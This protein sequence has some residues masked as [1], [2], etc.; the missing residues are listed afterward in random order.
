M[1]DQQIQPQNHEPKDVPRAEIPL[2]SQGLIY[3]PEHPLH[4]KDTV[5][6]RMMTVRDEDLLSSEPLIRSRRAID[7]FIKSALGGNVDASS[8]C[9][10]DR[11]AIMF[12]F[13]ATGYGTDY[14]AKVTC[15][16]CSDTFKYTFDLDGMNIKQL[17][18][19]PVVPFTNLFEIP[20]PLPDLGKTVQFS[21][22]TG[23]SEREITDT[24]SA[25]SKKAKHAVTPEVSLR[26]FY[27]IQ[28]IGNE[29]DRGKI[30]NIVDN[31]SARDGR[32]LRGHI[33]NIS[34]KVDTKRQMNCP[35]CG[36]TEEVALPIDVTFFF[37]ED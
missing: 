28:K 25:M 30:R 1:N 32:F 23:A 7:E 19:P 4:N 15:P 37:P 10:G 29:K 36:E 27:Q 5:F 21:I 9:M 34:P 14:D 8:L 17:G 12:A 31:M 26:L 20:E 3:P 13:R 16:N 6:I 35:S 11:E 22:L 24:I 2:P 33:N 18:A